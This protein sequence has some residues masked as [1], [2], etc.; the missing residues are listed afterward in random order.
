[1]LP[2]TL[3]GFDGC[4]EA[5]GVQKH[6]YQGSVVSDRTT[7]K[8]VAVQKNT[9]TPY[10]KAAF[11]TSIKNFPVSYKITPVPIGIRCYRRHLTCTPFIFT[12]DLSAYPKGY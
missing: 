11:Y 6:L 12:R 7:G 9:N 3:S 1:L 8:M 5:T 2:I 4:R 10:Q